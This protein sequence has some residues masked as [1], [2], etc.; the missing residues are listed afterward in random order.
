MI[1]CGVVQLLLLYCVVAVVLFAGKFKGYS[2]SDQNLTMD[3]LKDLL[4]SVDHDQVV[5][6]SDV[7]SDKALAALLDRSL[8]SSTG[9]TARHSQEDKVCN[10]G[11]HSN[12]FVVLEEDSG[13]GG[14][15]KGVNAG[16][17]KHEETCSQ[18]EATIK[19]TEEKT[20]EQVAGTEESEKSQ[21][22]QQQQQQQPVLSW[23]GCQEKYDENHEHIAVAESGENNLSMAVNEDKRSTDE[24]EQS[25]VAENGSNESSVAVAGEKLST[26]FRQ[27]TENRRQSTVEPPEA[28]NN[29]ISQQ[30]VTGNDRKM[31]VNGQHTTTDMEEAMEL[32]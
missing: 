26:K 23:N 2:K 9:A 32:S 30:Q 24:L 10:D 14:M 20:F 7:I 15:L 1:I 28:E 17:S 8:T 16:S 29:Y 3:D 13:N 25:T 12:L 4:K 31:L 5:D 19:D 11:A 27:L 6:S 22:Q 21:Q 18:Q